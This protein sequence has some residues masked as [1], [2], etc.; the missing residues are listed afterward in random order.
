MGLRDE[1]AALVAAG[2][3]IDLGRATLVIARIAYPSLDPDPWLRRL[4]ALAAGVRPRLPPGAPLAAAVG[5]VTRYLFDE[6]GFHGNQ[7]DY[8]DPRNSY[9]NDVLERRTGIP[10]SLSVLLL[11]VGARL[12]LP[13]EGVGFPGHFLVRVAGRATPVLLDPFFGGRPIDERE[14]LARYRALGGRAAHALPPDALDTTATP[15]ILM[16][17]LRNLLRAY[18][19]RKEH[20]RALAATDLLL[21]LAPDSADELRVRGLLY[22]HLECFGAALDDFRRYLDLAPEAG[23]ADHIR[24]RLAR[25]VRMAATIH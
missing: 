3:R 4:D 8:Y 25:L 19:D 10:I 17:M 13:L 22:E 20:E 16:R 14:L 12:G 6:C 24:E 15:G 11:E 9:L 21:V 2:E 7:D 18:L 23:D 1:F 5:E